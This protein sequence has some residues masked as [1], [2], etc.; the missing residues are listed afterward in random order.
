MKNRQTGDIQLN[1]Q[2]DRQTKQFAMWTKEG[3][4]Y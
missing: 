3:Q 2:N 4:R 1:G